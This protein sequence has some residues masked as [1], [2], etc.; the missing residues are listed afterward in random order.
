M[1]AKILLCIFLACS[2]AACKKETSATNDMYIGGLIVNPT[3]KFVVLLKKDVVVDTFYLDNSNKFGGKLVNAEEGLYVFKHPPENQIMYLEPGDS[4]LILLNTLEFDESLTFSGSGAAKSNYL[5][6]MYLLNQE[7]NDLVISYYDLN[8]KEFAFKTDSIRESR[9]SNLEK[10]HKK[11]RFSKE[12]YELANATINYEFYDLRE[13][14]AFLIRKYSRDSISSIPGDFHDYRSEISFNDE[15]L[16]DY[17]VY[18]NLIDDYLRTRSLEHCETENILKG[19]CYDLTDYNNIKRR[20]ILVDSLIENER[21]KNSFVD[22]L[23]A[24]GIIYSSSTQDLVSILEL[25]KEINYSGKRLEDL[26]QMAG[27]QNALLPGNNL[28]ELKLVNTSRDTL[29]LNQ[30]SNKPIISYHWSVNS[31]RHYKWQ[32]KI[33][34]ELRE[35]YPEVAFIGINIDRGQFPGW[36]NTIEGQ[37]FNKEYEYKLEKIRVNEALLKNYLNKLIFLDSSGNILKGDTQLTNRD[38]ESQ[39]LEFINQQ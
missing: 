11:N 2:L 24:Q 27:I 20:I 16:E 36:I 23:A 30:I 9:K 34:E 5:N 17:Y 8:P 32:H 19:E 6:E 21:I 38:Y 33:I 3:S 35:K 1:K 18:L 7:N 25:L 39:I 37:G 14:Y 31:Q 26:K 29:K 13:R 12:F 10:L 28:G 22:R 15:K 4:T